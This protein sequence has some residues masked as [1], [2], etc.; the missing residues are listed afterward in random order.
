[1]WRAYP[2]GAVARVRV[3][4]TLINPSHDTVSSHGSATS[5]VVTD[6][7]VRA[8][9][10]RHGNECIGKYPPGT[11]ESITQALYRHASLGETG[12]RVGALMGVRR[13]GATEIRHGGKYGCVFT[14]AY[15]IAYM[16]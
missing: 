5:I 12:C 11:L 13:L 16:P 9:R 1:M 15:R 7:G 6:S 4:V 14:C 3:S 10:L 2:E 8:P